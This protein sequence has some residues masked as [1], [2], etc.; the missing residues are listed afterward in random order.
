MEPCR[1]CAMLIASSGIT[2]IVARRR[3]HAGQD[4]RRILAQAGVT[5]DIVEEVVETYE[6]Q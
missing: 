5:L 2:R 3:Y 6:G 4:S 1:V